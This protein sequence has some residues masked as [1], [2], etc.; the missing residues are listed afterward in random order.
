MLESTDLGSFVLSS[1]AYGLPS[2]DVVKI[3]WL[4]S[5]SLSIKGLLSVRWDVLFPPFSAAAQNYL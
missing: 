2:R 5:V 4:T 3:N 1:Q